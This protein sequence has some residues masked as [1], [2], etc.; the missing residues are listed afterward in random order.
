MYI[1]PPWARLPE[2]P[3]STGLDLGELVSFKCN[4]LGIVCRYMKA[5]RDTKCR[6]GRYA[7]PARGG[8]AHCDGYGARQAT[9][10]SIE[11]LLISLHR[12]GMRKPMSRHVI[13]A[14]L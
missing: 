12:L 1:S 6:R 3:E 5:Y 9:H 4:S 13:A 11:G 8:V 2:S 10:G 7:A 14:I